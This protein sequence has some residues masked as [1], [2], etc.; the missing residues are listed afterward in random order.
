MGSQVAI[1]DGWDPTS[2]ASNIGSIVNTR[3]NL[4]QSY[5][6]GGFGAFMD[7]ARNN[8]A[9]VCVYCHTPHGA[10]STQAPLWNRT[11]LN[12]TFTLYNLPLSS[13]Q[14]PVQPGASSVT[15]LSCHDGT[16]AV[17]S[18]IN[19]P[20]SGNYSAAQE[21]AVNT[22]FLD[23]WTNS[24]GIGVNDHGV[25]WSPDSGYFSGPYNCNRCHA[26]DNM[27]GLAE[28]KVFL[29]GPDLTN[30]HPLGV[31]LPDTATYDFKPTTA[32]TAQ[33]DFYD[34]N[35]NGRLNPEDIRFYSDGANYR[36]ECATCHDPHG[37]TGVDGKFIPTFL[38]KSNAQS[39]LCLTCH[40]K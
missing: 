24:S 38:R 33:A 20:G 10:S 19:M 27:Q 14:I 30:D 4:T 40:V 37:V 31:T 7:Y 16:V 23:S 26:T 22:A 9:E 12:T 32:T 34:V 11:Q 6:P 8:Y 2:K 36:V 13:G 18:V 29:I 17:D 21:S 1:A 25:I 39:A 35:G 28:F 3:H 15:C 5:I